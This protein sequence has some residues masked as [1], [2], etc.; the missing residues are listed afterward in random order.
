MRAFHVLILSV[1]VSAVCRAEDH[2]AEIYHQSC[3]ACHG[4][5]G[6]GNPELKS[7]PIAGL[8]EWYVTL[9]LKR[10][11]SGLR[12]AHPEDIPGQQMAAI[13]KT[14]KP[15][16]IPQLALHISKMVAIA[17]EVFADANAKRGKVLYLEHCAACHRFNASGEIAFRSPP[18]SGFPA[19]Y[20]RDQFGK[21]KSGQRGADAKDEDGTK[22]KTI[23]AGMTDSDLSDIIA[24]IT[25]LATE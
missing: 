25:G 1:T 10:F 17:P 19:W 7:P 24:H 4:E 20:L 5:K 22:M 9:Q 11:H 2:A 16:E 8:A 12:G 6:A 18:L 21:F 23:A 15:E 3:T 14:L 13:A